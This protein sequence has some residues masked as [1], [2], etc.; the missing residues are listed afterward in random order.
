VFGRAITNT[1]MLGAF[2]RTTGIVSLES[3]TRGME[4]VAFRDA[5]LEKNAAAVQRGYDETR[6]LDLRDRK[7]EAS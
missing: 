6:R 2:A 3:L 4:S 1:I 7:S 5:A